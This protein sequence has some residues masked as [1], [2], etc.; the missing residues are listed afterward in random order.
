MIR[1]FF[2]FALAAA[3]GVAIGT[4][5]VLLLMRQ[6]AQTR[7]LREDIVLQ[8]SQLRSS[9]P[10]QPLPEE[11][12]EIV[13][14]QAG[15]QP[16]HIIYSTPQTLS[17]GNYRLEMDVIML[18]KTNASEAS[19][20]MDLVCGNRITATASLS[21]SEPT[22]QITFE[23][24]GSDGRSDFVARLFCSGR[25]TT[26]VLGVKFVRNPDGAHPTIYQR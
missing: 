17:A 5:G 9:L 8:R 16:G 2:A 11:R 18:A 20:I 13:D 22:P 19:C 7:G 4:S 14:A 6:P 12:R 21:M 24:P 25:D 15:H 26:R 23:S 10:Q 1:R 3:A